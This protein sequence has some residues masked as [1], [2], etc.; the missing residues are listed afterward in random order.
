M[1]SKVY[2]RLP[3]WIFSNSD[4]LILGSFPSPKSRE[5]GMYYGHRQNRFWQVLAG[6][7]QEEVPSTPDRC[8]AFLKR[9]QLALWDVIA[10][11]R[12]HGASDASISDAVVNDVPQLV[13]DFNIK[14][15]FVTGRTAERLFVRYLAP[16]CTLSAQYLPSPSA[17]NAQYQLQ[18]LLAAYQIIKNKP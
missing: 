7:W 4:T 14:R 15:L 11:C 3:P 10:S 17:A 18:D 12:I 2:H 16:Y 5:K 1:L 9:H 6:L 13:A 8:Q